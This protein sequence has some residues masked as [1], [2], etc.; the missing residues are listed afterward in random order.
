MIKKQK[1]VKYFPKEKH[2]ANRLENYL[3]NFEFIGNKSENN[4]SLL[5]AKTL[6]DHSTIRIII[7]C[8]EN[9]IYKQSKLQRNVDRPHWNN[10]TFTY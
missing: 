1:N 6:K 8:D 9:T 5:P 3:I 4:H 7:F 2:S 10:K